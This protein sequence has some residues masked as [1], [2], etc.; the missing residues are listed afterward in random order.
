MIADRK[1]TVDYGANYLYD[2]K[3]YEEIPHTVVGFSGNKGAF[4][5]FKTSL[6]DYIADYFKAECRKHIKGQA[7]S[8]NL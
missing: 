4:E 8:P 7:D 1:F 3:L 2:N 5:L 6:N